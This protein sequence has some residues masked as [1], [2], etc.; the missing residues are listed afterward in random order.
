[1]VQ[2]YAFLFL[3]YGI[4]GWIWEIF[5]AFTE[6]K[7][8]VNRGFLRSPF[9]P[10][11]AFSGITIMPSIQWIVERTEIESL[12]HI[13][14]VAVIVASVIATLWEYAVSYAMESAFGTRWWD[15]SDY[16]YHLNGRIALFSSL[17]WG[18]FGMLAYLFLQ[19]GLIRLYEQTIELTEIHF[20]WILYA[21][22]FIDT[23][24][25]LAE[26]LQLRQI[27]TRFREMSESLVKQ[28]SL[29][30]ENHQDSKTI[31]AYKKMGGLK[32][33]QEFID[34]IRLKKI[35]MKHEQEKKFEEFSLIL[36]KAKN[37]Q[38]FYRKYPNAL[39]NK[40]PYVFYVIRKR[41]DNGNHRSPKK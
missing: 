23:V 34:F 16:K 21:I 7:R 12:Q 13:A 20:L 17:L 28:L 36:K 32:D 6:N 31:M 24:Y 15:Y 26:L 38:R 18:I 8:F 41:K 39:T 5:Y 3:C 10:I 30:Q 35:Q 1:M 9:I 22:L 33:L 19:P 2:E 14:I 25:T 29:I 27:I 11:Y 4:I 40:L 37:I